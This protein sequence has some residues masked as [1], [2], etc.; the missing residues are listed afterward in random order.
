MSWDRIG[1]WMMDYIK[2]FNISFIVAIVCCVLLMIIITLRYLLF[3][4]VEDK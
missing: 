2:I 3:F 4:K 1:G